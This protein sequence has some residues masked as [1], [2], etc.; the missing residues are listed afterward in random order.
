MRTY[1]TAIGLVPYALLLSWSAAVAAQAAPSVDRVGFTGSGLRGFERLHLPVAPAPE[2]ALAADVGYGLI[3]SQGEPEGALH[4]AIGSLA[5]GA[6]LTDWFGASLR[7]DGRHDVHPDDGMGSDSATVGDPRLALR[8]GGAASEQV[9][10]GAEAGLWVPGEDAPSLA[11]DAST[12]DLR[13]TAALLPSA[14]A[15]TFAASLG[16]RIDN[17]AHAA[18]AL[19][20]LR[21]G[22]RLSLSLSSFNAVLAALALAHRAGPL[23]LLAETSWDILVGHGAPS[24]SDSPLRLTLGARVQLGGALQ[25]AFAAEASPS[26]RARDLGPDRLVPLEPRFALQAGL[27]YGFAGS[28]PEREAAEPSPEPLADRAP[29][30]PLDAAPQ[31]GA[32][33]GRVLDDDGAPVAGARVA[34]RAPNMELDAQTD[35]QGVYRFADVPF[36]TLELSVQRDGYETRELTVEHGAGAAAL[37]DQVLPRA[38]AAVGELRGLALS[39]RGKPVAAHIVV[40]PIDLAAGAPR[41]LEAGADGRFRIE[42]PP[43]RYQVEVGA[44]GFESQTRKVE[45]A[46]DGVVILNLDLRA[47]R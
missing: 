42:L 24:A 18:P 10:L 4:R 35:A 37:P 2:V 20:R 12:L 36:G 46:A 43:G 1:C 41:E 39:F 11:L 19:E 45:I 14:S 27:R 34:L 40:R 6:A 23:E 16:Y 30:P 21:P 25:L 17:S 31:A 38:A 33:S 15:W 22:D 26:G 44:T 8:F 47:E 29:P 5:V 9:L 7:F 3:E 28:A 13:A 32:V